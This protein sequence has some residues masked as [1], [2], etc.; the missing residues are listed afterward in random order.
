MVKK[1]FLIFFLKIKNKNK[2]IKTNYKVIFF[3]HITDIFTN[4]LK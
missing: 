3:I 4:I 1:K 2:I